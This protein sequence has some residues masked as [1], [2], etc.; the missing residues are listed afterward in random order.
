MFKMPSVALGDTV[1]WKHNRGSLE[2]TPAIVTR[3]GQEGIS[4][5]VIPPE[6]R[7]GFSRDGVRHT[8]DPMNLKLVHSDT[9]VWEYT[10]THRRLLAVEESL[11]NLK[12]AK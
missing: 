5:L 4:L 6:S 10:E 1:L 8:D 7:G 9:G 11:A 12:P 3:V 2:K